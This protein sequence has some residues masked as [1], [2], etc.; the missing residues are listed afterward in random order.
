[1]FRFFGH[2]ISADWIFAL[3]NLDSFASAL[4]P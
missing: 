2:R 3:L 1:M 4:R